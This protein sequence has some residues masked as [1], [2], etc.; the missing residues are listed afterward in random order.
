[1]DAQLVTSLMLKRK[2]ENVRRELRN[3]K[4]GQHESRQETSGKEMTAHE[5]ITHQRMGHAM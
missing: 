4:T 1:M 5:R 2:Q 3:L